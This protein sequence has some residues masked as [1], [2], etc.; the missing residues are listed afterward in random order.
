MKKI[1]NFLIAVSVLFPLSSALTVRA[2]SESAS[3][4]ETVLAAYIGGCTEARDLS[5]MVSVGAVLLRRCGDPRFPDTV[6]ANAAALGILPTES[7]PPMARYAARLAISGV[8]PTSG[9]TGFYREQDSHLHEGA[10][11]LFSS[12]G[13]IFAK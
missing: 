2:V 6:P 13:L 12:S 10:I 1:I 7:P 11:V 3:A 4:D 9:A 5:S 8:D